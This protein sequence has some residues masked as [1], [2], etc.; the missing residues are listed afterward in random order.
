MC[1]LPLHPEIDYLIPLYPL[2]S[3]RIPF[4]SQFLCHT[5]LVDNFPY[6]ISPIHFY[7]LLP[8]Q[9]IST[10]V[11]GHQSLSS[12]ST[13]SHSILS[14]RLPLCLFVDCS[15]AL[16]VCVCV[17]LESRQCVHQLLCLHLCFLYPL[18]TTCPYSVY[19]SETLYLICYVC[20]S[21]HLTPSYSHA[22][23][24]RTS[25]CLHPCV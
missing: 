1:Q 16:C 2:P 3:P 20:A 4:V 21:V 23:E 17:H 11:C 10:P 22:I 15:H 18:S 5:P 7:R 14:L 6:Q 25:P 8:L 9:L 12:H 19:S 24:H 13:T